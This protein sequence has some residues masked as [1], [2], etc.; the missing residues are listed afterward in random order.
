MEIKSTI[1]AVLIL[2]AFE[3]LKSHGLSLFPNVL[4]K[5]VLSGLNV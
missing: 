2:D 3:N 4:T 1:I 5:V